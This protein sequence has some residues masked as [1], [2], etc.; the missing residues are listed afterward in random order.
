MQSLRLY[1]GTHFSGRERM[2]ESRIFVADRGYL[3]DGRPYLGSFRSNRAWIAG[4]IGGEAIVHKIHAAIIS[5][6]RA[7]VRITPYVDGRR[8]DEA[9]FIANVGGDDA[10]DVQTFVVDVRESIEGSARPTLR[11]VRGATAEVQVEFYGVSGDGSSDY[12]LSVEQ[13]EIEVEIVRPSVPS[14]ARTQR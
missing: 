7:Q 3:D 5:T 6:I 1:L 9:V 13:C 4:G 14:Q 11:G 12:L 2:G 8:I 10:P